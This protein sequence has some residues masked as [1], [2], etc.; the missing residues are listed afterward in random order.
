[1]TIPA[2][3]R[4][5]SVILPA[6]NEEENISRCLLEVIQVLKRLQLESW[7]IIVINDGSSDRTGEIVASFQQQD[8]RIQLVNHPYN[9]GYGEAL[10]SGI[11]VAKLPWLFITDS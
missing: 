7:E 6:Y 8:E 10:L 9:K 3:I 4:G 1:M 11:S 5:M 2:P